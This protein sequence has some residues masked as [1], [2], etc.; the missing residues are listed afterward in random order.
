MLAKPRHKIV[1]E[2]HLDAAIVEFRNQPNYVKYTD[3]FCN[4]LGIANKPFLASLLPNQ[5]G[6]VL[7][8]CECQLV[9]RVG[10]PSFVR[11]DPQSKYVPPRMGSIHPNFLCEVLQ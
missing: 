10:R 3:I 1:G 6:L 8:D 5:V 9:L 11:C 2:T 7:V 4:R